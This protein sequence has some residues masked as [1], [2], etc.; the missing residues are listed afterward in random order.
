M[1]GTQTQAKKDG[2]HLGLKI[3]DRCV[4]RD[5][6]GKLFNTL[7]AA[8]E[9]AQP[10]LTGNATWWGV[11]EQRIWGA[12]GDQRCTPV[13]DGALKTNKRT[14]NEFCVWLV[15]REGGA[16]DGGLSP[17]S[18]KQIGAGDMWMI[19]TEVGSPIWLFF[20]FFNQAY[21]CLSP[22]HSRQLYFFNV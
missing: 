5:S 9:K 6:E 13:P 4:K 22:I 2:L 14:Q 3:A 17:P 8:M 21:D 19:P 16:G 18:W 12:G 20:F 15:T 1:K 10:P 7:G 11:S